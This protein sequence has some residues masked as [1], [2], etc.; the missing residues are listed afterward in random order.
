MPETV[1]VSVAPKR[2]ILRW[3]SAILVVS[4]AV[5]VHLIAQVSMLVRRPDWSLSSFR[6]YF[7]SDQLSYMGIVADAAH[8]HFG[9]F[10]PFTETGSIYYPRFYYLVVGGAA[11][12]F[13]I[14][15]TTAWSIGG[16]LAQ[17]TLVVVIAVTCILMSGKIWTG[18]LGAGPFLIGTFSTLTNNNWYTQLNSHAVLW[19]PFGV[20]FTLNAE[21]AGL[22]AGGI[23]L[24]VL[25]LAYT[26]ARGR[27]TRIVL[28]SAASLIIGGLANVQTYSFLTTVYLAIFV[29]AAWAVMTARRR[30]YLYLS[31]VL[32]PILFLVGPIIAQR[33]SPLITLIFG[34]LPAVP[35]VILLLV[36]TRGL[37]ALYF[38]FTALA[39][40]P[41]VLG[42][43]IGLSNRDPF[44]VYRVA[45][46]KNL[47]V[48]W[49]A[50]FVAAIALGV[51]LA[52]VFAAGLHRRRPLWIA[53]PVGVAVAWVLLSTNDIWGAN[54][55]PY[56][57]WI[58]CFALISITLLPILLTV[59]QEYLFT[60]S[61]VAPVRDEIG[62]AGR[63]AEIPIRRPIRVV[64]LVALVLLA[65]LLILSMH[66]WVRFYRSGNYQSLISYSGPRESAMAKA[67]HGA[68]HGLIL[69]DPC[70]NPQSL[71]I[72]SGARD[73]YMNFGMAWPEKYEDVLSLESS[74]ANSIL[75]IPTAVDAG[76]GFVMT[77]S[78]C[79]S[80][81]PTKYQSS[82]VK[83]DSSSYVV[84]AADEQ[85]VLWRLKP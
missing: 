12:L 36:R 77:D 34:L 24:L 64:S 29:A 20:F 15:P 32:I 25:L 65:A 60:R 7:A 61:R 85:I 31:I 54:Q 69:T 1:R 5:I 26:R 8:G 30:L 44:L 18:V 6:N 72:V 43:L 17:I 9:N 16:I 45:S 47:G 66:D 79:A 80:N 48:E 28:A 23:A 57:F 71:K 50:G 56:R 67:A 21:S 59:V 76:V 73:V 84:G 38:G 62:E 75:D 19:G 49:P 55:E 40:S 27:T 14:Q 10:E 13:G 33:G 58:D 42:T 52:L 2:R 46:S 81:W 35:G 37:A 78:A 4:A 63:E 70:I 83:V 11:H 22:A 53:Y 41:S 82:L 74:T 68:G 3:I 39:A 51:P